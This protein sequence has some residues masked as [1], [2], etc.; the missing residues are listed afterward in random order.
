MTHLSPAMFPVAS[1]W[2][3]GDSTTESHSDCL[4]FQVSVWKFTIQQRARKNAAGSPSGSVIRVKPF[5]NGFNIFCWIHDRYESNRG[6][7]HS[8]FVRTLR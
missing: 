4:S 8:L 3:W 5:T 2:I 7:V 6:M 1:R